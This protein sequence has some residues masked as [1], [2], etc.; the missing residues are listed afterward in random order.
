L[1]QKF[2][3]AP[4]WPGIHT[5]PAMNRSRN[6]MSLPMRAR[7]CMSITSGCACEIAVFGLTY[8]NTAPVMT[9]TSSIEN[10]DSTREKPASDPQVE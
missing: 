4:V 7:C 2:D 5:S 3:N 9:S 8:A 1:A 6:S 10:S